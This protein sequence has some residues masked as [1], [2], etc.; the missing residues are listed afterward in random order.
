[1][2]LVLTSLEVFCIS[3]WC[4]EAPSLLITRLIFGLSYMTCLMSILQRSRH[5]FGCYQ[6]YFFLPVFF[7]SLCASLCVF[8]ALVSLKGRRHRVAE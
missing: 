6:E 2:A 3:K 1:M 7:S 4:Q 5:S 8:C